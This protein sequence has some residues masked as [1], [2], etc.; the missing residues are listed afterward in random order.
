MNKNE[1]YKKIKSF[2][3]E[4]K[5]ESDKITFGKMKEICKNLKVSFAD[6]LYVLKEGVNIEKSSL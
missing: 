6:I 4:N 1:K 2:L 3:V 5:L